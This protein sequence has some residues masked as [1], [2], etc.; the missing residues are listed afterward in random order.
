LRTYASVCF[1]DSG[2]LPATDNAWFHRAGSCG[3]D[4]HSGH[5]EFERLQREYD[6]LS[7]AEKEDRGYERVLYDLLAR[8]THKMDQTI[9][10]NKETI[11]RD[12]Q[13][14]P[15]KAVD[16]ARLD[17]MKQQEQGEHRIL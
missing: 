11:I 12:N 13:P 14:R 4:V 7:D 15:I 1:N 6:A 2:H 16:Q 5:R 3:F 9:A 8:L 10:K 17:A